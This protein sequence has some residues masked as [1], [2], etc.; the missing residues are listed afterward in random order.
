MKKIFVILSLLSISYQAFAE[1]TGSSTLGDTTCQNLAVSA[2]Q[3]IFTI[4]HPNFSISGVNTKPGIKAVDGYFTKRSY[5][6]IIDGTPLQ[7]KDS[8]T[9]LFEYYVDFKDS[10]GPCGSIS[11]SEAI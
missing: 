7:K 8:K 6:V 11:I 9:G 5:Q 3:V 1:E 2:V 10:N 4:A